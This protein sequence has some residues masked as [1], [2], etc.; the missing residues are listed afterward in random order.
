MAD[1][2]VS[3]NDLEKTPSD[4][5]ILRPLGAA[6]PDLRDLLSMV[7]RAAVRLLRVSHSSA[8][9]FDWTGTSGQII[10]EY[11]EEIAARGLILPPLFDLQRDLHEPKPILFS[12]LTNEPSLGPA[13]DVLAHL[14]IRSMLIFPLVSKGHALGSFSLETVGYTREFKQEEIE[15]GK[16]LAALISAAI[17]NVERLQQLERRAEGLEDLR[18]AALEITPQLERDALLQVVIRQAV[19]LL[20]AKS[21]GVYE[22]RPD[23]GELIIVAECQR[24][25]HLG[26]ILKVGEGIAGQLLRDSASYMVV[27]DY[28]SWPGRTALYD[29]AYPFG[30]VMAVPLKWQGNVIG[31]IY[32]DDDT[33]RQFTQEDAHLLQLLADH[34]SVALVNASLVAKE[35]QTE[36]RLGLLLRASSLV[37]EADN[38]T[39]G[40]Q[41]LAEMLAQSL[42]HTSCQILLMNESQS[43][44]VV[45]AAYPR[46]GHPSQFQST[47]SIEQPYRLS[48]WPGLDL[49]LRAGRP[50]VMIA[51]D[52]STSSDL[53]KLSHAANLERPLDRLL[54]V[55]L[56]RGGSVV[57]L[58]GLG[59]SEAQEQ[60]AFTSEEIDLVA[61]IA[62]HT[63][64]LIDRLRLFEIADRRR[65]LLTL[66]DESVRSLSP[67]KGPVRLSQEITRLATELLQFTAAGLFVNRP[68]IGELQLDA[69]YKLSEQLDG[70]I[71]SHADELVGLV[72]RTGTLHYAANYSDSPTCPDAFKAFGFRSAIAVPLKRL[73]E[74]DAVLFLGNRDSLHTSLEPDLDILER[75]VAS[76]SN[77]LQASRLLYQDPKARQ[78]LEVFHKVSQYI[79]SSDDPRQIIHV[80]LTGVTAG[81]GL[82]FNRA[83]LFLL[84]ESRESLVGQMG[85]GHIHEREAMEVWRDQRAG[86]FDDFGAYLERLDKGEVSLTPIGARVSELR[87]SLVSSCSALYRV[88][89]GGTCVIVEPEQFKSE[90]PESLLSAFEPSSP[91]VI[92]PLTAH[93]ERIGVLVADNTFTHVPITSDSVESLLTLASTVANALD[94]IRLFKQIRVAGAES[95]RR[96]KDLER[97]EEAARLIS[98]AFDVRD[99]L[100]TIVT[101]AVTLFEANYSTVWC[102]DAILLKF[103]PDEMAVVASGDAELASFKPVEP[104]FGGMTDTILKEGY[105]EGCDVNK[106]IEPFLADRVGGLGV[107]SLQGIALKVGSEPVGVLYVSYGR[108][109]VFGA[110]DR[111]R[112]KN[113]A[114]YAALSLK[115]ARLLDQLNKARW[116]AESVAQVITL[117]GLNETLGSIAKATME[118]IG[119]DVVMLYAYDPATG[120]LGNSAMLGIREPSALTPAKFVTD[121][122]G[123][124]LLQRS[125]V[126]IS[127]AVSEDLLL[128]QS[129]FTQEELIQSCVAIPLQAS[130]QRVGLMFAGY[131]S[132]H[133]FASE[134]LRSIR[135]FANQAAVAIRNAQL[136]EERARKLRDQESLVALSKELLASL[137]LETKLQR[138]A[139]VAKT[140][141]RTDFCSLV[142]WDK[143]QDD[144]TF[145]AAVGWDSALINTRRLAKDAQSHAGYTILARQPVAVDDFTVER[146]FAVEPIT[147]EYGITSGLSVPMLSGN[148]VVGAMLVHTK[149]RRRF[150]PDEVTLLGLIANQTAIAIGSALHYEALERKNAHLNALLEAGKAITAKSLGSERRQILDQIV[151]QAVR[152]VT[153]TKG[154]KRAV[155]VLHLYDVRNRSLQCE[156]IY[157]THQS[158]EPHFSVGDTLPLASNEHG[159]QVG[160]HSVRTNQPQLRTDIESS[161]DRSEIIPGIRS[162]ASVPL[163][164]DGLLLGVL[165]V[166]S[167]Y[168]RAFDEDDLNTLQGLAELA[169]IAIQNARQYEELSKTKGL[170]GARTALAWMGMAS[171]VWRHAITNHASVIQAHVQ[172]IRQRQ[173]AIDE[174]IPPSIDKGLTEIEAL[175]KQIS[176]KPITPPL[177]SEEGVSE[178]AV[179]AFVT[180][181]LSQ[182]KHNPRYSSIPIETDIRLSDSATIRA[183]RDW[184]RRALDVL[185][186][187]AVDELQ[188]IDASN[189]H[190][191]VATRSTNQDIEIV[192]TD[193]G[194]GIPDNIAGQLFGGQVKKAEESKGLGMGL[195][196][197]QAIVETYGGRIDIGRRDAGGTSMV[198]RMP[199]RTPVHFL[200]FSESVDDSWRAV[201]E[202][203]V[204]AL[205]TILPVSRLEELPA[206]VHTNRTVVIIDSG[207][208]KQPELVLAEVRSHF[209]RCPIVVSTGSPTWQEAR[210]AFEAGATDYLSKSLSRDEIQETFQRILGTHDRQISSLGARQ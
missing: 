19:I 41:K 146:R 92:V 187:N 173:R 61:T 209:P 179:N 200:L 27:N 181:R 73:G 135:L 77:A 125:D 56:Q 33:Q 152:C 169:V 39:E 109:K 48:D 189:R 142:L 101:A 208:R 126:Y 111:R 176:E 36:R 148:E 191:S 60:D 196:M 154:P 182:L 104:V 106:G 88:V 123:E 76:A 192:V 202:R 163:V 53:V 159:R 183:S 201:L 210:A 155:G 69:S 51:K 15:L 185:I 18:H 115:K 31:V 103:L 89:H 68:Q 112:L 193:N 96:L 98:L 97:Q 8:T 2:Q 11:P 66:L 194:R 78:P 116:A 12:D 50:S 107:G 99:V 167:D 47:E 186:D 43:S 150:T 37:A 165:T 42:H 174:V 17:E 133:R 34:V 145:A 197:A 13:R 122:V 188:H 23:R 110:E 157:S 151:Q 65:R 108:P 198:L 21:G 131:R 120:V 90:L 46:S 158:L 38:P 93:N 128:K 171:N 129:R 67:N 127:E 75:F 140:V 100:Q 72:A 149:D 178:V 25:H 118:T 55:P 113:F 10:A 32:V 130:A 6:T 24:P 52:L 57:G 153:S 87:L 203:A 59:D 58:L 1:A 132:P 14:G 180:E 206:L 205:G 83:S 63:T 40:L 3:S 166:A 81:Y 184:L 207:W 94:N 74:V 22:Y 141:M 124:A 161:A 20:Q 95:A 84:D 144:L 204:A 170:V 16:A 175:A 138:A 117:G 172:L 7:C 35:K 54:L 28:G 147:N 91:V 86:D 4:G 71:L 199:A 114:D 164:D 9:L 26:T 137:T 44:L 121:P 64:V 105:V 195:L 70:M 162:E 5:P 168:P 143:V 177:S 82:G 30:A 190:L 79:Q 134:E 80:M 29:D 102:Y 160:A 136:F 49:I 85:I 62:Q 119:C 156:S 45:K 139:H